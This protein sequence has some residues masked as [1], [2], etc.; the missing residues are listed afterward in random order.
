MGKP[1][2]KIH[3]TK[4]TEEDFPDSLFKIAFKI[5]NNGMAILNQSYPIDVNDPFL[6]IIRRTKEEII[7]KDLLQFVFKDD[8]PLAKEEIRKNREVIYEVRFIRGDGSLAYLELRG[9]PVVY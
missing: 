6:A 4:K 2:S 5:T 1:V 7:G 8:V 9:H 3:S